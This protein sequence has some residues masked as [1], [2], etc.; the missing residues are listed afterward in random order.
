M[1]VYDIFIIN[2]DPDDKYYLVA[3]IVDDSLTQ[4]IFEYVCKIYEDFK[5][6]MV[7]R[8]VK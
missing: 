7:E 6:E 3:T 4:N 2:D 5:F 8:T 1:K